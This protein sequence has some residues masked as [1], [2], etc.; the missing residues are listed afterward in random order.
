M[1]RKKK[2]SEDLV[3]VGAIH[4]LLCSGGQGIEFHAP[5]HGELMVEANSVEDINFGVNAI[6]VR[7]DAAKALH[8]LA[9]LLDS[10]NDLSHL[11]QENL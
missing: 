3:E 1:F 5:L 6:S 11:I 4:I 7:K 9:D 2:K 10:E 8:V